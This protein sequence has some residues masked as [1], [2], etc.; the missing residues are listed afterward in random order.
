M[1]AMLAVI[2]TSLLVGRLWCF[3]SGLVLGLLPFAFI[4][5]AVAVAAAKDRR[6]MRERIPTARVVAMRRAS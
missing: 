2:E 1:I 6:A 5:A 3:E 4:G